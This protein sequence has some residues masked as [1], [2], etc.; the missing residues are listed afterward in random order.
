MKKIL[1]TILVVGVLLLSIYT[2]S[3]SGIKVVEGKSI[4]QQLHDS[5]ILK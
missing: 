1:S 5:K 4:T 3:E 2:I